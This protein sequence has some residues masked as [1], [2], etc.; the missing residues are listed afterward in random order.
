RHA[1]RPRPRR[2]AG[3]APDRRVAAGGSAG[4]HLAA[5]VAMVPGF[6]AAGETPSVSCKPN[7]MLLFNPALAVGDAA[8]KDANGQNIADKFWPNKFLA[9]DAPPAI[10]FFG[11]DDRLNAGGRAYRDKAKTL[12]VRAEL[13]MAAGQ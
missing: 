8:I 3:A 4:G 7:A 12:G 2:R 13:M 9:K 6:D 1:V 10:I 11:T 5:A